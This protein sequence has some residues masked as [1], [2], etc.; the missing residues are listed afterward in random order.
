M[1]FLAGDFSLVLK[2]LLSPNGA[3]EGSPGT[4]IKVL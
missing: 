2:E 3:A 1:W 4:P